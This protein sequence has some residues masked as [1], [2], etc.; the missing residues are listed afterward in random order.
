[1]AQLALKL[2]LNL[3]LTLTLPLPLRKVPYADL[4]SDELLIDAIKCGLRLTRPERC[5]RVMWTT[6]TSCWANTAAERPT[7]SELCQR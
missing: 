2:L 1:M 4:T 5:P 3:M 6:I 7:P